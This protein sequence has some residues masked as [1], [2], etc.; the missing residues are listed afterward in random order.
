MNDQA[1]L[2]RVLS[3]L[4][5]RAARNVWGG[6][7][8]A[9]RMARTA[10]RAGLRWCRRRVADYREGSRL[11]ASNRQRGRADLIAAAISALAGRRR[12][13]RLFCATRIGPAGLVDFWKVKGKGG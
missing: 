12:A 8:G 11:L 13:G 9:H 4:W 7:A 1:S 6:D 3:T 2:E 5:I 10:F